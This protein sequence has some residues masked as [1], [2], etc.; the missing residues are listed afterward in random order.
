M[1]EQVI[2]V[3]LGPHKWRVLSDKKHPITIRVVDFEYKTPWYVHDGPADVDPFYAASLTTEYNQ[4]NE[5]D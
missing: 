3:V 4:E 2:W 1:D 5:R